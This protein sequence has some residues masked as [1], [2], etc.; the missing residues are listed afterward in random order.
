VGKTILEL[1]VEGDA[2]IVDL[3]PYEMV[4]VELLW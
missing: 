4:E 3:G 2:V 1:P